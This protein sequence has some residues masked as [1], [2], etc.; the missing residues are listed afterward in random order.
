MKTLTLK[1]DD[2]VSEK[3]VWLLEHFSPNEIKIL[4]QNEYIDDDTYLR[5][6]EDMTQSILEAKNEPMKNGV[7]LDKLEW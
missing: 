7:A 2:S 1:I 4:E 6:I 3:F 5:R